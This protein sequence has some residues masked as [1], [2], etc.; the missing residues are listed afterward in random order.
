MDQK[1][2]PIGIDNFEML[3]TRGYYFVDKTLLIKDLLDNKAAVNLFTRPRRFGKTLN[4]SMLQYY[5]EDRRD[6]FTGKKIDNSYLFEGLNIKGESE[7]YTKYIGKYPVINISLKSAKQGSLDLAFQC[8]REEI[9]NEFTRHKYIIESDV[10][11]TEKEHFM[12]IVNNDKDMSLYITALKFLSDCLNKYHNE[13]V[14]ILIDEYDVPLENAFFEGFYK[15]MIGF[16]RSLFESALKTNSS[17]EFSVITGCLRISKESIFTG[18]NNLKIIS[19]LDDRYAEHFGFT[20]D[21]VIKI[22][23]DYNIQQ[24]YETIKQWFNGYIFGET[25]VY[26][27]WSVMQYVDDL[28]ANINRL[29]KSYWANTSSNSIVKSLIERADDITKGEIEALIEGKTIEKPVHE[30]ITYDDVYDNLDNL[31]NLWNFMFFTGYFKKISERM[32][33]NTQ[34]KFVELAIPNLEVKYIFRTKILKWFNEH[35]KL[36]DMTKMFNAIINKNVELF[37]I[38]LNKLLLDTI[39]FNDAYENFYHGFLVGVLSN[40]KGYIVKSNREGGTGRSDLF[41]KSVSRRGIA[42]VVEFKIAN[43]IDDLEKKADEAIEQIEDRKYDMELRS[44]GYKNIFKYGIAFYK[45]DCLIKIK[46]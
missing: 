30:D 7:K 17:L 23:E 35:I 39:S 38:E 3:I 32:D 13:K 15:E 21:E 24:K 6:E 8:I 1:P 11:K 29:P 22:C 19:I 40:M 5:F 31:D 37:E 46:D 27:P 45:K 12:K 33:E 20:D 4:I 28:K 9:S 10:L 2:L 34:E 26:N 42:I 16:I 43:N 44:E 18:L 25:N 41:I 14:I 36:C